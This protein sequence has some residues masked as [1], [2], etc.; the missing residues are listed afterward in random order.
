[1]APPFLGRERELTAIRDLLKR[2]NETKS[3]GVAIVIGDPG[4]GKSRLLSEACAARGRARLLEVIGHEPERDVPLAAARDLLTALAAAGHEGRRLAALVYE[5]DLEGL[6][7][8]RVFEGAHRSVTDL[9]PVVLVVDDLQW[10]DELTTALCHYLVRAAQVVGNC[11]ALL[12]A[13]RASEAATSLRDSVGGIIRSPELLVDIALGP[14][15]R[16]SGTRLAMELDPRLDERSAELLWERAGG[17]PFW[18]EALTGPDGAEVAAGG[19]I[20]ARL[21]G[22][23][24]DASALL[25]VVAIAAR[26]MDLAE[27]ARLLGW[28]GGRVESAAQ[29]LIDHGI[30]VRAG[31]ALSVAHDLIRHAALEGMPQHLRHRTHKDIAAW[32]EDQAGDDVQLLRE[33]LYHRRSAAL[34]CAEVALRA[35]QSPRRRLLTADD[36]RELVDITRDEELTGGDP[37]EL[38]LQIARAASEL[39]EPSLAL[40]RWADLV[41]RLPPSN[42]KAQAALRASQAALELEDQAQARSYL[43]QCRS[44]AFDDPELAIEVDAHDSQLAGNSKQ[45][46]QATMRRA[47]GAANR[48]VEAAGGFDKLS[49]ES[50]RAYRSALQANFYLALRMEQPDEMLRIAEDMSDTA[51]DSVESRLT[52][53]LDATLALRVLGRYE[54][55]ERR[56]RAT[57]LEARRLVLPAIAFHSAYLLAGTLRDLGRLEEAKAA[58]VEVVDLT[59]RAQVVIPTFLS[60]AWIRSLPHEIDISLGEWRKALAAIRDLAAEERVPHFRLH[61]WLVIGH[62]LARLAGPDAGGEV[63]GALEAAGADVEAAGCS[64]CASEFEVRAAQAYARVDRA[65]DARRH[66]DLWDAGHHTPIGQTGYWR[67]HAEALTVALEDATAGADLLANAIDTAASMR[68]H[69]E[70]TW[71]WLDM[72][73]T[74][75]STDKAEAVGALRNA[76]DRARAIGAVSEAQKAEQKLRALG[77]RTWRR[78]AGAAA[79]PGQLTE[80]ELEIARLVMQGASNPEVA[81]AVFLSRKTIERHVS[82]IMA[83]LGARNRTEVASKLAQLTS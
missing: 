38:L 27:L 17:L 22:I 49:P 37:I 55:A 73:S 65:S 52:A 69:L 81:E 40:E 77:V 79:S 60:S 18:L 15:D 35:V 83:K 57:W 26:P 58:A 7:P 78:G 75:G 28:P 80:R 34:P 8:L 16:D 71:A 39:A 47:V 50:K 33:A 3:P 76:L 48:M 74:L 11:L 53:T 72:G 46:A 1:M 5:S 82:N 10:V 19:L 45:E 63:V 68:A 62:W 29:E 44:I 61:L 9:G 30:A 23:A 13:S 64:R 2:S 54:D 41:E 66:L 36:L 56:C 42:L 32:L 20:T 21:A 14:L 70:E 6:E 67:N 51:S 24:A 43:T 59:E 25:A 31:L 12:A 4:S